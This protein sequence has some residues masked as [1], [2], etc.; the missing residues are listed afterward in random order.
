MRPGGSGRFAHT[1]S[2][3]VAA[4]MGAIALPTAHERSEI[5]EERHQARLLQPSCGGA[6]RARQPLTPAATSAI[7]SGMTASSS[8]SPLRMPAT[9]KRAANTFHSSVNGM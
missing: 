6:S 7:R 9:S 8:E 5:R 4:A 1:G 2:T 3:G